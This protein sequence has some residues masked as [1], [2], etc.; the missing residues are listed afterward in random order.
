MTKPIFVEPLSPFNDPTLIEL[1][2][3]IAIPEGSKYTIRATSTTSDWILTV[4]TG[5][6]HRI[7]NSGAN[8]FRVAYQP[9]GI[10][11]LTPGSEIEVSWSAA[12][13]AH[14][15]QVVA[16]TE[17]DDTITA[18][19]TNAP[20]SSAVKTYVDAQ[21]VSA[22]GTPIVDNLAAIRS[23]ATAPEWIIAR[24]HTTAMDG[25][26][27]RFCRVVAS[28]SLVGDDDGG[29]HVRH[30]ATGAL[31]YREAPVAIPE[32]F[33]AFGASTVAAAA[34]MSNQAVPMQKFVDFVIRRADFTGWSHHPADRNPAG[35]L[36]ESMLYRCD[37]P[38]NV[39][40]DL[41]SD[42]LNGPYIRELTCYG[43]V[44]TPRTV[45]TEG[46]IVD[47]HRNA[48]QATLTLRT[49][50][51]LAVDGKT[52]WDAAAW[53]DL[54]EDP[55]AY[56]SWASTVQLFKGDFVKHTI[57][58]GET[59]LYEVT[60]AGVCG[61][62]A[63][64][65]ST[66]SAANGAATLLALGTI[67]NTAGLSANQLVARSR[68]IGVNIKGGWEMKNG[69][70]IDTF[71]YT[72]GI[73]MIPRSSVSQA[74]GWCRIKSGQQIACKMGVVVAS[75]L[76]D[77]AAA[78]AT[79]RRALTGLPIGF[80][81]RQADDAVNDYVFDGPLGGEA[82]EGNW[83]Q[84]AQDATI[85]WVNANWSESGLIYGRGNGT[86]ISTTRSVYG[87]V[88]ADINAG[89]NPSGNKFTEVNVENAGTGNAESINLLFYA[90]TESDCSVRNDSESGT[91]AVKFCRRP[92]RTLEANRNYVTAV[93][94]GQYF[95]QSEW[96]KDRHNGRMNTIDQ[97]PYRHERTKSL[98]INL[99][100][101]AVYSGK[102]EYVYFTEASIWRMGQAAPEQRALFGSGTEWQF[103][104][105][106]QSFLIPRRV[107][108][109]VMVELPDNLTG[110]AVIEFEPYLASDAGFFRP[111]VRIV[112][113]V[114]GAVGEQQTRTRAPIGTESGN[115][116]Q[117]SDS[118]HYYWEI[119]SSLR[120]SVYITADPWIKKL[121]IGVWGDEILGY[122]VTLR[123]ARNGR[124]YSP[125]KELAKY[126]GP[127]TGAIP[128]FGIFEAPS[129]LYYADQTGTDKGVFLNK[130]TTGV[131][132]YATSG[133]TAGIGSPVTYQWGHNGA[134]TVRI[135]NGT[136][137]DDV[138]SGVQT[139]DPSDWVV[140]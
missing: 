117:F 31:Y 114:T 18:L 105:D 39:I 77:E 121:I 87:V 41:D 50:K 27:G 42:W 65:H 32:H 140:F 71:G 26:G 16:S 119:A 33:G 73:A 75:Y 89:Y 28:G 3:N 136:T 134:G 92:S 7:Q 49:V 97:V 17:Y 53:P 83:S 124:V 46:W 78:N 107:N 81:V 137:W 47:K 126:P 118:G 20:K 5:K 125:G 10:H 85:N 127:I 74:M 95:F 22:S 100:R 59:V 112:N 60:V 72:I 109:C 111:T 116:A 139:L 104:I 29:W 113:P 1:S 101:D 21:V 40:V 38:I 135:Y 43:A 80:K 13:S 15:V 4:P 96:R 128:E 90:G 57:G 70:N 115:I 63:P 14:V 138:I 108:P 129:R 48:G 64:T 79:A 19:S 52:V 9:S 122:R 2:S 103:N 34:A 76:Y 98:D 45:Q 58:S 54:Y 25:G 11:N 82:T 93:R 123:R 67:T 88:I 62:G 30:T 8:A 132:Y 66:G 55:A 37:S 12:T 84:V 91:T 36:P 94:S 106:T 131:L 35:I 130:A 56:E 110:D 102:A 44:L 99:R 133:N 86:F 120:G 23:F 68:D 61:A 24:G 69:I 51:Q 6:T